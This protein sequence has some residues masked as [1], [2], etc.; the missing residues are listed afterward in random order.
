MVLRFVLRE[1]GK[2]LRAGGVCVCL[3]FFIFV[4][5][6]ATFCFCVMGHARPSRRAPCF[7]SMAIP[8]FLRGEMSD[9][10]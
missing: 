3:F 10:F 9:H 6:R 1:D 5:C 8:L 4:E 7:L 2:L